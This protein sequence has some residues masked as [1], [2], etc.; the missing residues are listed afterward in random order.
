MKE[1]QRIA[2]DVMLNQTTKLDRQMWV[3]LRDEFPLTFLVI[4]ERV[5]LTT[6]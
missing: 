3:A 6:R 4:F 2:L 5:W 1:H